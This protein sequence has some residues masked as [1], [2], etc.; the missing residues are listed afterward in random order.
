MRISELVA[1]AATTVQDAKLVAEAQR[2]WYLAKY[3]HLL[4]LGAVI[5]GDV[6]DP[7]VSSNLVYTTTVDGED[8][9]VKVSDLIA[10]AAAVLNP[11]ALTNTFEA[12]NHLTGEKAT[13]DL[14]Q[15]ADGIGRSA[16]TAYVM[17]AGYSSL[18]S[19]AADKLTNFYQRVSLFMQGKNANVAAALSRMTDVLESAN[20][21]IAVAVD[22]LGAWGGEE[23]LFSA[24]SIAQAE[25]APIT[26]YTGA[27]PLSTLFNDVWDGVKALGSSLITGLAM[28][29]AAAAKLFWKVNVFAVKMT[30]K[31]FKGIVGWFSRSFVNP[32]DFEI[33]GDFGE[34]LVA[35]PIYFLESYRAGSLPAWWHDHVTK[36]NE[37]T[38][39]TFSTV[40]AV[41]FLQVH[42]W[43]PNGEPDVWVVRQYYRPL[44]RNK[45][46]ALR[47]SLKQAAPS[48]T[49]WRYNGQ[50][51]VT[52]VLDPRI[53]P[54]VTCGRA[55]EAE[56]SRMWTPDALAG[57][58]R[59]TAAHGSEVQGAT[60][61][62]SQWE[63]IFSLFRYSDLRLN[64]KC[65]EDEMQD[66]ILYARSATAIFSAMLGEV[67]G[68]EQLIGQN[69]DL[70]IDLSGDSQLV[71]YVNDFEPVVPP[72]RSGARQ[73]GGIATAMLT[74]IA[75]FAQMGDLSIDKGSL[76]IFVKCDGVDI[77]PVEA[78]GVRYLLY[79]FSPTRGGASLS[80]FGLGNSL[81]ACAFP[82]F[83]RAVA[84]YTSGAIT[85]F[86]LYSAAV[87]HVHFTA[88]SDSVMLPT[89]SSVV[90]WTNY[91]WNTGVHGST[92]L[93]CW[94]S[95]DYSTTVPPCYAWDFT[96]SGTAALRSSIRHEPA[97]DVFDVSDCAAGPL[98]AGMMLASQLRDDGDF[99][100]VTVGY[101]HGD[102]IATVQ[103]IR[104]KTDS[105]NIQ[106]AERAALILVGIAAATAAAFI[107]GPKAA[108]LVRSLRTASSTL[109]AIDRNIGNA[110]A[111]GASPSSNEVRALL[112]QRRAA[113][114][115]ASVATLFTGSIGS[116][117]AGSAIAAA[118]DRGSTA[119][120]D[121]V[122][123]ATVMT[124][125]G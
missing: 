44:D 8:A 88:G 41:F 98:I 63:A 56:N 61:S 36:S 35:G 12:F 103:N 15:V 77:S 113:K 28:V 104:I 118:F 14:Y 67:L 78:P 80:S 32:I 124:R 52:D 45:I 60:I 27:G 114:I 123:L 95:H 58:E 47:D 69:T 33:T 10:G 93:S 51:V 111:A 13:L 37:S 16:D 97:A 85:N 54:L 21:S 115:K 53:Y 6:T 91:E 57:R 2:D 18:A 1:R 26:E 24:E 87:N 102:E 68:F 9:A 4:Q 72:A 70:D 99:F 5:T 62:L 92:V 120:V 84:N 119:D 121:E 34:T 23:T 7:S 90:P 76:P 108:A 107:L 94:P 49:M 122:S 55:Y 86:N 40:G 75:L 31:I 22:A 73:A 96:A 89:A 109:A 83:R 117:L 39:Y 19:A 105:E 65:S 43:K 71:L 59:L 64:S 125:L 30:A 29:T 101:H 100:P 79:P 48:V 42:S 25:A 11:D 81:A 3:N 106:A 74:A 20:Q 46:A 50:A 112:R 116:G 82:K 17:Y 66:G 110:I 38:A